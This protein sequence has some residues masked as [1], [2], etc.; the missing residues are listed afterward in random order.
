MSSR[1]SS[2]LQRIDS[3]EKAA[4][5]VEANLGMGGSSQMEEK[6]NAIDGGDYTDYPYN[7]GKG[8]F[9]GKGSGQLKRSH[10]HSQSQQNSNMREP[11]RL[12][13]A[14]DTCNKCGGRGHWQ[15][16]VPVT[17]RAAV[18]WPTTRPARWA[19]NED[20]CKMFS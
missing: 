15:E 3:V 10:I 5:N 20:Y 9:S 19:A 7:Q 11:G 16:A 2:L 1:I 12:P 14:Q 6:G 4:S 8:G 18:S 13:E 17:I